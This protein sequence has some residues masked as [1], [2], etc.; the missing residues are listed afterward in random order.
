[1]EHSQEFAAQNAR[2]AF[3]E[4]SVTPISAFVKLRGS[5]LY[6]V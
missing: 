6:H 3:R 5:A 4:V 1:M 2:L